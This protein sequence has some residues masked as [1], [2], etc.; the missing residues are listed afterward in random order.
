MILV[1]NGM[2]NFLHLS[3][4]ASLLILH[5]TIVLCK[6]GFNCFLLLLEGMIVDLELIECL[7]D[8]LQGVFEFGMVRRLVSGRIVLFC[9]SIFSKSLTCS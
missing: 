8:V 2:L 7:L 3:F 6:V 5:C 1:G 9:M 4:M